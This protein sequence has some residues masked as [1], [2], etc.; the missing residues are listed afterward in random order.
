MREETNWKVMTIVQARHGDDLDGGS[1]NED[2]D[3]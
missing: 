3:K 2:N 1:S